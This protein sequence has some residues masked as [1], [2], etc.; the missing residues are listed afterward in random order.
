MLEELA[1]EV[2]PRILRTPRRL[3]TAARELD[4]YFAGTRHGFDIPVDLQLAHGFR[5]T[6][7]THLTDIAYGETASYATV[8]TAI[9]NPGAVRAVGSACARNPLPLVLPCHRVVRSDGT[10]GQ[11]RGGVEAKQILLTLEAG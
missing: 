9:G 1:A 3:D 5:R 10:I 11:Y 8:A 4:E 2:S 7:I 6:V